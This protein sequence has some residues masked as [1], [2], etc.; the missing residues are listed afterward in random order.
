MTLTDITKIETV[1]FFKDNEN[2]IIRLRMV[3]GNKYDNYY[4]TETLAKEHYENI[5]RA[6]PKY[7]ENKQHTLTLS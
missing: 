5:K 4:S 6:I 1:E 2:Y 3:S 7:I